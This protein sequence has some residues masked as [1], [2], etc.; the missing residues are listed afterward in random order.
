MLIDTHAHVNFSAYKDDGDAV[1][2]RSLENNIWM[3]NVGSEYKSSKRALDYANKYQRGVYAAIGLHPIHT[4]DIAE[5]GRITPAEDFNYDLYEKMTGF[6]KVV[7]IGE[8][9]LDY[10]HISELPDKEGARKRQQ[11]VFSSQLSLAARSG[12]PAIIHCREAHADMIGM[13]KDFRREFKPILPKDRPWAVMHCFSG[14][15]N[16]AWEYFSLGLV[17]S[18]TGLIT[19]VDQWD[20][21]LRKLPLDRFMVET[22]CPYMTPVPYR[23]QRNEPLYVEQV[24]AHIAKLK[25]LPL[26]K[27]A[28]ATSRTARN[29]FRI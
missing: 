26:K 22:D 21:L 10:H 9:G 2:R 6:E 24:A 17:V 27:V 13:L 16:L 1:I 28:E 8:I 5:N 11:A 19:F 7:A 23:G 29:I 4:Q 3:I 14:D 20:D 25:G 12:L 15:E 18:F